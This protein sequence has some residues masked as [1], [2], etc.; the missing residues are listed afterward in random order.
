MKIQHIFF[1][2]FKRHIKYLVIPMKESGMMI[3]ETRY[4]KAKMQRKVRKKMQPISLSL[5]YGNTLLIAM[6]DLVRKMKRTSTKSMGIYSSSQIKKK[7]QKKRWELNTLKHH[8]LGIKTQQK[9]K[10]LLF[11]TIGSISLLRNSLHMQMSI[12]QIKLLIGELKE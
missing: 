5:S 1:K 2:K 9:R 11:M 7:S 3:T 4:Y 10:Y 6:M 8:G 12:I